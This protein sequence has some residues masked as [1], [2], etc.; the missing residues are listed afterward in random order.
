MSPKKLKITLVKSLIGTKKS[1]TASAISFRLKKI[2]D[3]TIQPSNPQTM[4]KINKIGHLLKV[5]KI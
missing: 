5:E 4:G 3:E 1:Q 2:G